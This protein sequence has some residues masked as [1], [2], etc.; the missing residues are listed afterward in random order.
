MIKLCGL[1]LSLLMSFH[2]AS[3]EVKVPVLTSP[4]MDEANLLVSSERQ[5]ISQFIQN[6]YDKTQI[7]FQVW[8]LDTLEGEPIESVAIRAFDQWKLGEKG[9]D[10]GLLFILAIQD[11]R[12]RIEVGRGLE[13]DIPDAVANRIIREVSTPYFRQQNFGDGILLSLQAAVQPIL[14]DPEVQEKLSRLQNKKKSPIARIGSSETGL[15][16]FILIIFIMSILSRL[17][18]GGAGGRRYRGGSGYY[19]GS[20]GGGWSSGGGGFGGGSGWGG[21]GGGSSGG[22][23]SGSW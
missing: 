13:G 8:I 18:G 19:G 15:I 1:I 5:R 10:K 22:G 12:M 16:L 20:W 9:V 17:F 21:G 3:A 11:R 23:S 4:V 6:L 7:Q 2:L 14:K